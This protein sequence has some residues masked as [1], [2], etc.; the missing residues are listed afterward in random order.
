MVLAYNL[1]RF[2]MTQMAYSLKGCRP[3]QIGF[4]K[5]SL[6]L[7]EQLSTLPAVAPGK[8]PKILTEIINMV[9]SFVLPVRR[10]RHYPRAV[11]K[12]PQR[13]ALRLP[14]KA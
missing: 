7:T 6:Y 9:E 11:K 8:I 12:K 4:K 5:A 10:K 3:Y 1:L 14:A 13:Y 2:M